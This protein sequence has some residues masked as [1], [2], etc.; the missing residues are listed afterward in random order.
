M[1]KV[2]SL[3]L[4]LV[5]VLSLTACGGDTPSTSTNASTESSSSDSKNANREIRLVVN[6]L[7]GTSSPI[8]NNNT[9]STNL[10][11]HVYEG[12]IKYDEMTG[13]IL[14][15]VAKRWKF[16]DDNSYIDFTINPDVTFHDGSHVTAE[17]VVYSYNRL[18]EVNFFGTQLSMFDSWEALDKNT[19]R[20]NLK[21][22]TGNPMLYVN[23]L[24]IISKANV[25]AAGEKAFM[26]PETSIGTGP[27]KFTKIDF[28]GETVM[29]AYPDYYRGEA[30]IKKI[31]WTYLTDASTA[32]VAFQAGNFD[33]ITLPAAN[34]AEMEA[35]NKYQII[36][37]PSNHN[38]FIGINVDKVPDPL[39]RQAILYAVNNE[40]LIPLGHG[41]G[42]VSRN[43]GEKGA[44][45]GGY[46]F[47]DYYNYNPDKAKEL[48]LKAG[49][50]AAQLEAGVPVGNIIAIANSAY[51]KIAAAVQQMLAQVGLKFEVTTFEQAT[52]EDMWYRRQNVG[53]MAMVIHG[54]Q[55]KVDCSTFYTGY[56]KRN[57]GELFGHSPEVWTLGADAVASFDATQRDALWEQFWKAV[58]E[59]AIYYSLYHKN[60]VYIADPNLSLVLAHNDYID[61]Y[62]WSW[63]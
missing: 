15:R 8:E 34:I 42:E 62:K 56:I 49:Y 29:E 45:T 59:D 1:K 33:F 48:L 20:L 23:D 37:M 36:K 52:V 10:L 32:L 19:F 14:G 58:K 22:L 51:A 12:L 38:T 39:V 21:G 54:D 28:D 13:E 31:T 5:M 35:M 60:N 46:S 27:Y 7:L 40:V 25:E 17:D 2:L 41:V 30:S 4:V 26:T 6:A 47:D 57:N 11:N 63:K 16:A 53:D 55:I 50:T 24:R 3:I 44:V 61:V 43:L 9:A 18:T